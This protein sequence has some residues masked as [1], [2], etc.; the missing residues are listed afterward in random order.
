M[1][2]FLE[3]VNN[4][5]G[6][7]DLSVQKSKSVSDHSFLFGVIGFSSEVIESISNSLVASS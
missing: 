2:I 3:T 7:I 1:R 6:Q 5:T 4:Q